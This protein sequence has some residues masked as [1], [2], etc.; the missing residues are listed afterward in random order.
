MIKKS[1]EPN[2]WLKEKTLDDVDEAM[3]DI[4]I[5]GEREDKIMS[6]EAWEIDR[7]FREKN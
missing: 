2:S 3:D 5:L 7:S 1:I 4:D 6:D